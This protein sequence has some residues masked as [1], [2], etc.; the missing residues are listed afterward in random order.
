[1]S[2]SKLISQETI[3]LNTKASNMDEIIQ[4][5]TNKLLELNLISNSEKF[6][7]EIKN[8]EAL[9]TTGFGNGIAIP[10]AK[11]EVVLKP[12]LVC[13]KSEVGIDYNAM[14][15]KPV[16][17]FFMIATPVDGGDLHL[18]TLAKLARKLIYEDFRNSLLS[19][20]SADEI[21]KLMETIEE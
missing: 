9:S 21:L 20:S 5:M 6:V 12:T 2:V 10:H 8:R 15:Q 19:A 18:K 13:A 1:M 7:E 11:S 4:E 17:L 3:L 14:D 16:H